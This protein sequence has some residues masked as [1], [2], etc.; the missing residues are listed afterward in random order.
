MYFVLFFFELFI[1]ILIVGA[2]VCIQLNDAN[3]LFGTA[4][5]ITFSLKLLSGFVFTSTKVSCI[6]VCLSVCLSVY[7][8]VCLS[9][10]LSV[11]VLTHKVHKF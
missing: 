7:L 3:L 4:L 8:S 6:H 9:V 1:F 5:L 10:C 2:A 11:H